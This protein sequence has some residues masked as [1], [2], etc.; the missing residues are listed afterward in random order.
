MNRETGLFDNRNGLYFL[1]NPNR[2]L[3]LNVLRIALLVV[4]FVW[5]VLLLLVAFG[6]ISMIRLSSGNVDQGTGSLSFVLCGA[7]LLEGILVMSILLG[8]MRSLESLAK[9]Q[10][11]FSLRQVHSIR[12]LSALLFC[13]GIIDSF[14]GTHF[15]AFANV[16]FSSLGFSTPFTIA[17]DRPWWIPEINAGIFIAALVVLV[18]SYVFEYGCEL[19]EE[20]EAFL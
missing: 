2:R 3:A 13:Y 17:F 6:L 11:P 16:G 9:K 10:P 19:Q 18:I 20:S 8:T 1:G 4:A 7:T 12:I 14:V 5:A 15:F